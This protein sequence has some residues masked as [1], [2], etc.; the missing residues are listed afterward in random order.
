MKIGI[1][2]SGLGGLSV[3]K[4]ISEIM[5]D[6]DLVYL[7]DNARAPYGDRSQE[8]IY[9][10]TEQALN[11]LFTQQDCQ[12]VIIACNTASAKA[13]RH[14]QQEFLPINFPDR[15]VLGVIRPIIEEVG[16]RCSPKV[17]VLATRSTVESGAYQR[18]LGNICPSTKIVLQ[19]AP[20]LVPLIEEGWVN[21]ESTKSILKEYIGPL[22]SEDLDILIPACTHY[23]LLNEQL[24]ELVGPKVTILDTPLLV[25]ESL[26]RY[27][28][29][30]KEIDSSLGKEGQRKY[31]VTEYSDRYQILA[32]KLFG[33]R[34]LFQKVV[35]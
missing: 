9:Q 23:S 21:H 22:L 8:I 6:Y 25:A 10:F 11:Y 3:Y 20:L 35:I 32:E 27:L 5:S 24:R 15:K 34:L 2:D 30:H 14:I 18:E 28:S 13:L 17:A 29:K 19:A 16:R 26:V 33:E 4:K 12:L 7:G 1:F 31:L